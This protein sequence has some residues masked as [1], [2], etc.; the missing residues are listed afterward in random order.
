MFTVASDGSV[1]IRKTVLTES[2][3]TYKV[4]GGEADLTIS[5]RDYASKTVRVTLFAK[6]LTTAEEFRHI[7]DEP[8]A[9]YIMM[10]DID[11]HGASTPS[12][13]ELSGLL[14]GNGYSVKNVCLSDSQYT[15]GLFRKVSGTIRNLS[16]ENIVENSVLGVMAGQVGLL[17]VELSGKVENVY[18]S[19]SMPSNIAANTQ[20]ADFRNWGWKAGFI[21]Q[22]ATNAVINNVVL[23]VTTGV[24]TDISL[25]CGNGNYSLGNVFAVR[26]E[27]GDPSSYGGSYKTIPDTTVEISLMTRLISAS[28]SVFDPSIWTVE[29]GRLA[30]I[31]GCF[32]AV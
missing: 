17:A 15:A 3:K 30:L 9:Y 10:N 28:A 6:K 21:C 7:S 11:F 18:L 29:N 23:D 13:G 19:G 1:D 25:I 26:H 27:D 5:Y 2:G 32:R 14:E 20:W 16:L 22:T 31:K 24:G 4:T 12:L 8:S